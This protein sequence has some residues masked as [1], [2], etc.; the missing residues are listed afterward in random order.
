[1]MQ[2]L[3]E[4]FQRLNLN[5]QLLAMVNGQIDIPYLDRFNQPDGYWYPHPPAMVP[6][7]LG[8]GASYYG[9]LHHFF[10][11]REKTFVEYSLERGYMLEYAR[12]ANQFFAQMVLDMDI[13]A[14]GLNDRILKFCEDI[15]FKEFKQVDDFADQYGDI[16]DDYDKLVH[17]TNDT[18]LTYVQSLASYNGDY[19]AS[20]KLFNARQISNCCTYEIDESWYM[21][22]IDQLPRWFKKEIPQDELFRDYL[23]NDDLKSA[24]LT[25][26]SSGWK[27]KDVA[28]GLNILTRKT[29]DPLFHLV[30]ANWMEGFRNSADVNNHC[31]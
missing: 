26:N 20:I 7:F 13:V 31:Y 18:P 23:D 10:F 19:P 17:L 11:E 28:E 27:L 30:A 9:L 5:D 12:N 4:I 29:D 8:Y 15:A 21:N 2:H 24:W 16:T 1:M 22:N 14:D 3:E 25:L 6:V